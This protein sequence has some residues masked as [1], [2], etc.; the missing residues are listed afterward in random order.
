MRCHEPQTV[1][2]TGLPTGLR[3]GTARPVDSNPPQ[4]GTSSRNGPPGGTSSPRRRKV[5]QHAHENTSKM[6]HDDN[7]SAFLIAL[8]GFF[9]V[10]HVLIDVFP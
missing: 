7:Y 2:S 9:N 1:F 3:T 4:Q 10:H 5:L 6:R 8:S